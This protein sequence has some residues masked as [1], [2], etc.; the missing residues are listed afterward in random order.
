MNWDY[1]GMSL[2]LSFGIGL[3]VYGALVFLL[4]AKN[5]EL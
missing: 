4:K 2:L 1:I 5:D 3:V